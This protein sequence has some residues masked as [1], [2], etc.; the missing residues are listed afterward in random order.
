MLFRSDYKKI[1]D[2]LNIPQYLDLIESKSF[3]EH[4][5]AIT[6]IEA[7]TTRIERVGYGISLLFAGIAFMIIFNTIR[8]AI[9]TQRVEIGIKRL[10]GA[11]NWFIRGP[12]L[13]TAVVFSLLSVAMAAALTFLALH[14][15]DPYVSVVFPSGFTLTNYYLQHTLYVFGIQTALVLVLTLLSS[16]LAMRRQLKI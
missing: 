3:D 7:I 16:T 2:N 10:V 5:D 8:V 15:T 11:N 6:R 4:E 13:V 9:Y 14:Y 1:I 12:Y